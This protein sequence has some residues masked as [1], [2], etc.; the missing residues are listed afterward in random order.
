MAHEADGLER[1]PRGGLRGRLG[2]EVLA[3]QQLVVGG[4][5]R[6]RAVFQ[7]GGKDGERRE[8]GR[9][10]EVGRRRRVAAGGDHGAS[11]SKVPNHGDAVVGDEVHLGRL[12]ED[13]EPDSPR[14]V[15]GRRSSANAGR[16]QPW[17]RTNGSGRS[18][19]GTDDDFC[20]RRR[21]ASAT[22]SVSSSLTQM[23]KVASASAG[24]P[25]CLGQ[26]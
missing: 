18:V 20:I 22:R 2:G 3:G 6:G 23:A 26:L 15:C 9:R 21:A 12:G 5:E 13:L 10:Q 16:G 4:D 14:R 19:R 8:L 17:V 11:V 25:S 7:R 24:T 1:E